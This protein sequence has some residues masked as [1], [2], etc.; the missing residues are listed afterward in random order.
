[1]GVTVETWI[2]KDPSKIEEH[3][4]FFMKWMQYVVSTL[5][6]SAP[7]H[8]YF[9][10]R[11]PVGGRVLIIDF[12]CDEDERKMDKM[13]VEDKT[14]AKFRDEWKS[15]YAPESFIIRPCDEIMQET[16]KKIENK[17]T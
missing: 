8:R 10:Q 14:M 5:G 12:R 1:M 16:I 7:S 3:D 17:Y 6:K 11:E 2:V 4:E 9:A 13:R 15:K